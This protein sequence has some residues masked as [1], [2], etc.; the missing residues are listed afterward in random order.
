MSDVT[1]S[2]AACPVV[3]KGTCFRSKLEARWAAIFDVLDWA[4]QDED[5]RR[6]LYTWQYEPQGFLLPAC[7]V[8]GCDKHPE[9]P[10]LPDF[11]LPYLGLWVEVKGPASALDLTLM[12]WANHCLRG[13]KQGVCEEDRA[14]ACQEGD[15]CT[16]LLLLGEPSQ[17]HAPVV[18]QNEGVVCWDWGAARSVGF[19]YVP[20]GILCGFCQKDHIYSPALPPDPAIRVSADDLLAGVDLERFRGA[21]RRTPQMPDSFPE[22]AAGNV[23]FCSAG[24]EDKQRRPLVR[25]PPPPVMLS[26][27]DRAMSNAVAVGGLTDLATIKRRLTR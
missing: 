2:I 22:I 8:E 20:G 4:D 21:G 12:E 19:P 24:S 11:Y 14:E 15:G 23:D 5:R 7:G 3:Y 10:Y 16:G 13:W 6:Y 17:F 27:L 18:F 25:L 26:C 1:Y 9:R